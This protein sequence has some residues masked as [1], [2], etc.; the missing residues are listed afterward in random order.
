MEP[1]GFNEAQEALLRSKKAL[2]QSEEQR[3]REVFKILFPEDVEIPEPCM[4]GSRL[5]SSVELIEQTIDTPSRVCW[6]HFGT[7]T[8][9]MV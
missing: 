9:R 4:C 2:P 1:E 8:F 3:W 7:G 6:T 5:P